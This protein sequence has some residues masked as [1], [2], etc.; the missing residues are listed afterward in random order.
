[1]NTVGSTDIIDVDVVDGTLTGADVGD[2]SLTGDEIQNG[3]IGGVEL[4]PD[5]IDSSDI[6]DGTILG[7]DIREE[8]ISGFRIDDNTLTSADVRDGSLRAVD[9]GK[10]ST[11]IIVTVGSVPAQ[12]CKN[13]AQDG[14]ESLDT[15]QIL[16]TPTWTSTSSF[17]I[18]TVEA[19][20][21][22]PYIKVCNP[23]TSALN[24]GT[25]TFNLTIIAP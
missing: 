11:P 4:A 16:L 3:T 10:F 15:D 20:P 21:A 24:D 23:T 22:F 14:L 1:M 17:L 2:E 18:Y 5:A 6:Q 25:T 19:G 9:I 13:I 7:E 12:S 8:A